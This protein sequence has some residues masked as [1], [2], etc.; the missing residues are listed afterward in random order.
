[1]KE[2]GDEGQK[3]TE[4]GDTI[5]TSHVH[6]ISDA[7]YINNEGQWSSQYKTGHLRTIKKQLKTT[8]PKRRTPKGAIA[9]LYVCETCCAQHPNQKL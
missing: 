9:Q 4:K 7:R 1:V 2:E 5:M 8:R 6:D 3:S